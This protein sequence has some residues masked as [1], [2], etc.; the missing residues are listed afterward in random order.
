MRWISAAIIVLA[1]CACVARAQIEA[2]ATTAPAVSDEA[3]DAALET[4][5]AAKAGTPEFVTPLQSVASRFT[6]IEPATQPASGAF[7][8]VQLNTRG[9]KVDAIRFRVPEGEKRD[10]FWAVAFPKS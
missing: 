9:K 6:S 5:A 4:S 8:D 3:F 2:P 7:R 1:S 10:L